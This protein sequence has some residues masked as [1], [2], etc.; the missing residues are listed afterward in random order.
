MLFSQVNV[1][2]VGEVICG[3]GKFLQRFP[4]VLDTSLQLIM[5][6]FHQVVV[7]VVILKHRSI[8]FI[9]CPGGDAM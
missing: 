8:F 3:S 6:C 1:G 9:C 5:E 7:T 2:M 4:G